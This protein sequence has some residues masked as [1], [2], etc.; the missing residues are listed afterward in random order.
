MMILVWAPETQD[1]ASADPQ[2]LA[3]HNQAQRFSDLFAGF[4]P[5]RGFLAKF[6]LADYASYRLWKAFLDDVPP[7]HAKSCFLH[8]TPNVHVASHSGENT[9]L[10]RPRFLVYF[11]FKPGTHKLKG[12]ASNLRRQCR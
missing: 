1:S 5:L 6:W 3:H 12:F 11:E 9:A 10:M 8:L 4:E 2:R 7:I